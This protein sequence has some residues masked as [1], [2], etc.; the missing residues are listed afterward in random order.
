VSRRVEVVPYN[1]QWPHRYKS[2]AELLAGTLSQELIIV[3]HIGSTAIPGMSAKPIID[4]LAEVRSI[5]HIDSFNPAMLKLGYMPKG[6]YGIPG[7][8]FF[9]KGTEDE[10]S[11]HLHVF[12]TSNPEIARHLRFRDY[13]I[14]HPAKAAEYASLKE[15]LASRF[16]NDIDGYMQGKDAFIKEID[17]IATI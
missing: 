17:R 3:H 6:E 14:A 16:P 10:R 2:E 9:I 7:R 12:Q 5:E 11:C 4:I 13:M 8:R 15:Y 1:P